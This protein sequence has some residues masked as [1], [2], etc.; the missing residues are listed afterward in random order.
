MK[1]QI[2]RIRKVMDI[3]YDKLNIDL[4]KV[5]NGNVSTVNVTEKNRVNPFDMVQD[6]V[7]D[8]INQLKKLEE[9]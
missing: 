4:Y 5:E 7:R 6:N 9:L 8:V 2:D 1:E 3:M